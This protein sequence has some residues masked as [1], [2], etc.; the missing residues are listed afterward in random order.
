MSDKAIAAFMIGTAAA[1]IL[2]FGGMTIVALG[3]ITLNFAGLLLVAASV[4]VIALV[5]AGL[6]GVIK[7][8]PDEDL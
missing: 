5:A 3:S 6:Y 7:N 2:I 4:L 1:M 8:P